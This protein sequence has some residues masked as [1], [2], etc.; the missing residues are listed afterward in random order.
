MR[1]YSSLFL[2]FS[3]FVLATFVFSSTQAY[4]V[5]DRCPRH[6]VKTSVKAK[7][8]K[9]KFQRAS[10][11]SI[12]DYLNSHGVAAFVSNPL[13]IVPEFKFD[14][15]DIGYGRYCV[16][17]QEVRVTYISAPRIVMP[18]DYKSKSCEYQIILKHE[19]RH[20]KVHKDYYDKSVPQYEAFLGRIARDVPLSVPVTTEDQFVE[21][22]DAIADYFV[23][24]FYT[25][26]SK[27]IGEMR[28]LQEKIDSPQEYL[29]TGRKIDR[30]KQ[31]ED[32][33]KKQNSKVFIDHN[34]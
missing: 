33:K 32:R 34:R 31:T 28:R 21:V 2:C 1:K 16:M 3:F 24:N 14:L 20:L 9:T 29:F 23:D 27:S 5:T 7:R 19:K 25:Q 30:C 12:N 17:L 8:L 6:K 18:A 26:V 10:M 15:K 4:A 13:D 11:A 22:R